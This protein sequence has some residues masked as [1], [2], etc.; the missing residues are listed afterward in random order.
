MIRGI[1]DG[2]IVRP[3]FAQIAGIAGW[4]PATISGVTS[5]RYLS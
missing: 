3:Y 2:S 5:F 1:E 4:L